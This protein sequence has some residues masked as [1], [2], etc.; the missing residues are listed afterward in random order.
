LDFLPW[1]QLEPLASGAWLSQGVDPQFRAAC[2]MPAGWYRIQFRMACDFRARLEIFADT[3]HGLD[4]AECIERMNVRG[5]VTRDF[6]VNIPRPVFGFRFDPVDTAGAFRLEKLRMEPVS[7]ASVAWQALT[8]AMRSAGCNR[9]T[10]T[11]LSRQAT[12]MARGQ[13][14]RLKQN[15]LENLSG[16]SLLAPPSYDP[17]AA[18][19]AWRRR[20]QP[21]PA[22]RLRMRSAV[23][24]MSQTPLISMIMLLREEPEAALRQSLDSLRRQIYPHWELCVGSAD[25]DT[26]AFQK[27]LSAGTDPRIK[28][29]FG[30]RVDHQAL[31]EFA[32]GTFIGLLDPGDE[33]PEH[34]LFA[35]ATRANQTPADMIYSDE[36]FADPAG[37]LPFFKP[38]WSPEYLLSFPYTGRLA[39]YSTSLVRELGGL[40]GKL[41]SALEYDLVLRIA[42]RSQ[43]IAHV[44]DV[45]YHGTPTRERGTAAPLANASG[46]Y[47]RALQKALEGRAR[48]EPGP[49][50]GLHRVRFTIGRPRIAIVIP[51]AYRRVSC[52][53][54]TFLA[55]C[56]DS[57]RRKSTYTN[58]QILV[59]DNG[60][61]P[62][63]LAADFE[64]WKLTRAPYAHPFNWAAAINQGARLVDAEY[65]L[66]LD[67]DTEVVTPD[68]MEC[69]LE[70]AQ[71][72]DIGVVGARLHFPDG[73]LQ[74]A[75][76]TILD[77]VPGHPFY[78]SAADEPGYFFSSMVPRNWS[79]V[80]GACLMTRADVFRAVGGF[81]ESFGVN[82]ND[83]DYCLRV[84]RAG[85]RVVCTPF[86]R[87]YHHETATKPEFL[88][89]ELEVFRKRWRHAWPM[90][91]FANANLSRRFHDFRLE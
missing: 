28:S 70:Y 15:L 2:R 37:R 30:Q 60:D 3:G 38:D 32:A 75:G 49:L 72:P 79:A 85:R 86:A 89:G 36:D 44:S 29:M 84:A 9:A 47:A 52:N 13:V 27:L 25:S 11:A 65:L 61:V 10:V 54:E 34:A 76:V 80:T 19:A 24:V 33:L 73:R 35:M 56:L 48:V 31:V 42:S 66:V 59:L 78:R 82:F 17:V 87:L 8:A 39:L 6:F 83:I 62:H 51:T 71:Q 55:R 1:Q 22:D 7:R 26:G 77:G 64:R 20:R 67:D 41:G 18:Y 43:K 23:A 81:D 14:K 57:I 16:P 90:D 12:L 4:T 21:I 68:W 46:S 53:D 69:L 5:P 50:P 58:Y 88:P 40:R 63:D 74:H 45:L 91:P